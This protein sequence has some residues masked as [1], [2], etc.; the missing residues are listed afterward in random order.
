MNWKLI[1][2]VLL[3]SFGAYQHFSQRPVTYGNGVITKQEPAQLTTNQ[4][5]FSINNYT[6]RPLESFQIEARVLSATHYLIGRESDLS[7]VDLALGW[8]RMSDEAIL[9]DVDISQSNRFY[10]WHVDHFPIP[11][12]EIETHSAN[13][14][15][16]PAD[17]QI[18]KQLK[19]VRVGQVVSIKGELVE[20]SAP[21]GWHWKSSLTRNDTGQGACELVYVKEITLK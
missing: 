2:F 7:P 4:A 8:G 18:E 6:I 1:L 21:D 15:M 5:N 10:Y 3:I 12:E 13:M 17:N 14:H 11:R 20:V 16:I 9:K 19:S